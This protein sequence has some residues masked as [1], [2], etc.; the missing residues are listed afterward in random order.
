MEACLTQESRRMIPR[1]QIS[2]I[3]LRVLD[4]YARASTPGFSWEQHEAPVCENLPRLEGAMLHPSAA[5][6]LVMAT[7]CEENYQ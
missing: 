7:S 1:N 6:P 2:L 4:R 3:G 5:S